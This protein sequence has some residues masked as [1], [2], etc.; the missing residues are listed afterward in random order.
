MLPAEREIEKSVFGGGINDI[1]EI[2][3]YK[4]RMANRHPLFNSKN[5]KIRHQCGFFYP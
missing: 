3:L 5:D 1:N 2:K 4:K